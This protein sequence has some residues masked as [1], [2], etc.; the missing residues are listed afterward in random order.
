[1]RS[2]YKHLQERGQ[3]Q[4]AMI[5]IPT[6]NSTQQDNNIKLGFPQ[7]KISYIVSPYSQE[8]KIVNRRKITETKLH[9]KKNIPTKNE[10]I[11]PRNYPFFRASLE[12]TLKNANTEIKNNI[13][14]NNKTEITNDNSTNEEVKFSKRKFYTNKMYNANGNFTDKNVDKMVC[15]KIENIIDTPG[16]K[17]KEKSS[18][19]VNIINKNKENNKKEI[20]KNIYTPENSV[21]KITR[22][23]FNKTRDKDINNNKKYIYKFNNSKEKN[24]KENKTSI[25]NNN[26]KNNYVVNNK[27]FYRR[28]Y[29]NVK[30]DNEEPT[31]D[32][33]L[34]EENIKK[35][36]IKK[37]K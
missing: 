1:M 18:Q 7:H 19:G 21:Y 28:R 36:K 11:S 37:Q 15:K 22:H 5:P 35:K 32:I 6:N 23:I 10:I 12:N 2:K 31:Y 20:N 25:M 29:L 27:K 3:S 9:K 14:N 8:E 17:N 16:K 33:K 13:T 34:T 24:I 4:K 30:N 26:I